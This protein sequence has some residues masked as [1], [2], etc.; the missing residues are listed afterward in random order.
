MLRRFV[1]AAV[2][3]F[4]I[5]GFLVAGEYTGLITKISKDDV[6]FKA[7]AKKGEKGEDKTLKVASDVKITKKSKDAE[8]E[9]KIDDITKMIEESKGK[10]KGVF[11]KIT[12]EGEG[13]AEKVTKIVIGGGKRKKKDS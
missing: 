12:T 10:R 4:V 2:A 13:D 1:S 3:L 6:T 5:T 8:E 11:G 7:F 9:V